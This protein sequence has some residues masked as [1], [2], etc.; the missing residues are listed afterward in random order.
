MNLLFP[1]ALQTLILWLQW[2]LVCGNEHH[3]AGVNHHE[4]VV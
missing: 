4:L 2:S 1:G 3:Y